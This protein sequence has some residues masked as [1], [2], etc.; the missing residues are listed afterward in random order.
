MRILEVNDVSETDD[1]WQIVTA[2]VKRLFK[3]PEVRVFYRDSIWWKQA[4]NNGKLVSHPL[5][6]ELRDAANAFCIRRDNDIW[7]KKLRGG[8]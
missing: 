5:G 1:G 6:V 3:K 4:D 2:T 7:I 8:K